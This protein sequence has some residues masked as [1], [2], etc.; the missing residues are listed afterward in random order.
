MGFLAE[1]RRSIRP[2]PAR[3]GRLRRFLP[4][5][6]LRSSLQAGGRKEPAQDVARAP[7]DSIPVVGHGSDGFSGGGRAHV[8]QYHDPWLRSIGDAPPR[9]RDPLSS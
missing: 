5:P 4:R 1:R 7:D 2:P 8:S 3:A 9:R 6:P